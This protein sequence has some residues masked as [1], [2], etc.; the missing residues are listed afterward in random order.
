MIIQL[1]NFKNKIFF[2]YFCLTKVDI[3]ILIKTSDDNK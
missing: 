2:L 3:Q 1:G